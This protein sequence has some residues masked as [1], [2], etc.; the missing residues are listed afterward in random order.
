MTPDPAI[1]WCSIPQWSLGDLES[2]ALGIVAGQPGAKPL[3]DND[4][5]SSVIGWAGFT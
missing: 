1:T 2:G 5:M 3:N 4:L